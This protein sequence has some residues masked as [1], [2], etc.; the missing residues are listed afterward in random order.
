VTAAPGSGT[1]PLT[2]ALSAK[3]TPA[4]GRTI[5]G[6][7]WDFGDNTQ[8]GGQ[9]ASHVYPR[10]GVYT[11]RLTVTDDLGALSSGHTVVVVN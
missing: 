2:V 3:L 5:A 10:K 8:A 7:N 9:T 11:A 4:A 1:G 6:Y